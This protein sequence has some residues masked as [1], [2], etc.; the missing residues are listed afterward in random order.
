MLVPK[1]IEIA[2]ARTGT[3]ADSDQGE[4]VEDLSISR[5]ASA[6]FDGNLLADAHRSRIRDLY[7]IEP[8]LDHNALPPVVVG[9]YERV[10]DDI[11]AT[12]SHGID[13]DDQKEC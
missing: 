2:Q 4:D 13:I 8:L 5:I 6:A 3:F 12:A 1:R 11:A 10:R 9:V 7:L